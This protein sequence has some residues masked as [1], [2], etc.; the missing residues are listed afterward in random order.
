MGKKIFYG[1]GI[2][3]I[4]YVIYK[5]I[6]QPQQGSTSTSPYSNPN[7]KLMTQPAEQ[8]PVQPIVSPRVDNSNQPWYAG[9]RSFD[10][11]SP[12][13]NFLANVETIGAIA[14]VGDSLSSL[15]DSFGGFFSDDAAPEMMS[16]DWSAM[17]ETSNYWNA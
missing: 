4:G 10:A 2:L 16:Y 9:S 7:T 12:D 13:A 17:S 15:W 1:A 14:D 3:A 6:V 11:S 5:Y 8:Y